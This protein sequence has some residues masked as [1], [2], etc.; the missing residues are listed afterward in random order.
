MYTVAILGF[1]QTA[2][3]FLETAGVV[4]VCIIINDGEF[5]FPYVF[6]FID[7]A[8]SSATGKDQIIG[9]KACQHS[10]LLQTL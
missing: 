5:P 6:A 4:Q 7:S 8:D 1:E 3:T 10:P 9:V 2:Y